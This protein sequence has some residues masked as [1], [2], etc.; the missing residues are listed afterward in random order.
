MFPAIHPISNSITDLRKL[1]P[2]SIHFPTQIQVK[3]EHSDNSDKINGFTLQ[4]HLPAQKIG[5][6]ST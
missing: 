1:L 3:A 5:T 4:T 2:F 6:K